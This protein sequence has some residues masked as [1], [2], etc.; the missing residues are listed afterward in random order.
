MADVKEV[1]ENIFSIDDRLYSIPQA[2][3]VYLL[4]EEKKALIDTGPA[5]SVS[6]VLE[7]IQSLGFKPEDIDFI[8]I[9]HIHL[10]HSGGVG[11]II[12]HMPH[13]RV[14]AHHRA[15][16]HLVDPSKLIISAG[17]AQGKAT[18]RRNGEILPLDSARII[19]V[20]DGDTLRLG[21]QQVLTLL[22]T[23]GHAPHELCIRES[24][25]KGVFVGDAVGHY[26]E[27]M[28]VMVPVTPPPSFDLELYLQTLNRLMEMQPAAL[29]FAHSG[30][31]RNCREL[32]QLAAGKLKERDRFIARAI[33]EIGPDMD[34][35]P[36]E[37][38][39][40][41]HI[42]A[43]LGLLKEKLRAVYDDWAENDIPMSAREH[44]R[45]YRQKHQRM[46]SSQPPDASSR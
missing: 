5:T 46:Q 1:A 23:P 29:Y 39:L 12:K 16:K 3:V 13:A 33:S 42:C 11:T 9:T 7:G 20:H 44:V 41:D 10:D 19:P 28:D 38:R 43:E 8:I 25:N 32:L 31:S 37:K 15:V 27:G 6:T 40:A 21:S 17:D 22:E 14:A 24:R 26:I 35:L 30:V 34:E 4:A 18:I 2:G 36:V 45:Y